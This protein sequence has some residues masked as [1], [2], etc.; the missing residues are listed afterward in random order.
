MTTVLL[1]VAV[2]STVTIEM[3]V[4][5]ARATSVPGGPMPPVTS[6]VTFCELVEPTVNVPPDAAGVTLI[7]MLTVPSR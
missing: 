6:S 5:A 4:P 7:E 1:I 3:P 2:W